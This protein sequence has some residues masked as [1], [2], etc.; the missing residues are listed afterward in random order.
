MSNL[1]QDLDRGITGFS[2]DNLLPDD[3][4]SALF[5]LTPSMLRTYR[6]DL[7]HGAK[8]PQNQD[9]KVGLEEFLEINSPI[10]YEDH[11]TIHWFKDKLGESW[12]GTLASLADS[13][14]PVVSQE[15]IFALG[16]FSSDPSLTEWHLLRLLAESHTERSGK[17]HAVVDAIIDFTR[18]TSL[19]GE[20]REGISLLLEASVLNVLPR[21]QND[22]VFYIRNLSSLASRMRM[23]GDEDSAIKLEQIAHNEAEIVRKFY[24]DTLAHEDEDRRFNAAIMIGKLGATTAPLI[25]DLEKVLQTDSSVRV[26]VIVIQVLQLLNEK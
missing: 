8:A 24:R 20:A 4:L 11:A 15:A 23:L 18:R 9:T 13:T 1:S 25:P 10:T 16:R 26:K 22:T 3:A 21:Q 5:G 12:P 2:D 14:N 6:N 19:N 7:R 17:F